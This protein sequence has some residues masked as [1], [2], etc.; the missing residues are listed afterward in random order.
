MTVAD[1]QVDGVVGPFGAAWFATCSWCPGMP[2]PAGWNATPAPPSRPFELEP[3]TAALLEHLEL[4]HGIAGGLLVNPFDLL[5]DA[6]LTPSEAQAVAEV[7][8]IIT[9]L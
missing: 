6:G 8:R 4:E 2:S 1:G 7:E 9:E 3:L 5:R